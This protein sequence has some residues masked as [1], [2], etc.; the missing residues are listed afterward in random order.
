L[1]LF[2]ST[3]QVIGWED[4]LQSDLYVSSSMLNPALRIYL[5]IILKR[6]SYIAVQ[7]SQ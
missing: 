6:S 1:I 3:S 4:R 7:L 5:F 2:T